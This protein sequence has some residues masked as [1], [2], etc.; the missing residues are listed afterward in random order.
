MRPGRGYHNR[1]NRKL[2]RLK[3][4]QQEVGDQ[5]DLVRVFI[6]ELPLDHSAVLDPRSPTESDYS[7]LTDFFGV[8]KIDKKI[9]HMNGTVHVYVYVHVYVG[10]CYQR[11]A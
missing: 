4:F 8:L 2:K 9:I 10:R 11:A 5:P 1:D 3:D 6:L 7:V